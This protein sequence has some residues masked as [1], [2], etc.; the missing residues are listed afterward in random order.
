MAWLDLSDF[1][2]SVI[3]SLL[4]SKVGGVKRADDRRVLN[5]IFC[6]LRTGAPLADI[7]ARNSPHTT[8]VI[9]FNRR[10]RA[11]HWTQF[12][13]SESAS[14]DG[15]VQMIDTSSIR[16]HQHGANGDKKGDSVAWV[17]RAVA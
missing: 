7:P 15:N 17:A 6:R 5:G 14:Y 12:L 16:F 9:R 1:E 10:R 2:W 11:G 4:P 13:Y 8:C 3:E